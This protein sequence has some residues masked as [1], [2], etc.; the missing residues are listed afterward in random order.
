MF[1]ERKNGPLIV[2][3]SFRQIWLTSLHMAEL[4]TRLTGQQLHN[5]ATKVLETFNKMK[6]AVLIITHLRKRVVY[7][8][9]ND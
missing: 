2:L 6:K 1:N 7:A 5:G 4:K 3:L 8:G 9:S